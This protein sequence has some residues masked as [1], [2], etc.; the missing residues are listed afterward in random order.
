MFD[1]ANM[2]AVETK[3]AGGTC[4]ES[5]GMADPCPGSA[6]ETQAREVRELINIRSPDKGWG[7]RSAESHVFSSRCPGFPCI[8]GSIRPFVAEEVSRLSQS[9]QSHF[10]ADWD[11]TGD[12]EAGQFACGET[13]KSSCFTIVFLLEMC[14]RDARLRLVRALEIS[15]ML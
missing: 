12:A 8:R 6:G 10:T 5:Y 2:Q 9:D 11:W 1:Q 3:L 15:I 13:R 7:G 14:L 4:M